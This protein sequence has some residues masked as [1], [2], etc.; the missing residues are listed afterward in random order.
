MNE[1]KTR[2]E[3]YQKIDT[4]R[5]FNDTHFN[6]GDEKLSVTSF[7]HG[8]IT[9]EK[10]IFD[11]DI[12]EFKNIDNPE[13]IL[14]FRECSFNCELSFSN[15]TLDRL[16]INDTK[17]I[18]SLDIRKGL[19]NN[20]SFELNTFQFSNVSNNNIPKLS[21][22]FYFSDIHFKN[23][24]S[25]E[26]INHAE[27]SIRFIDN[28]FG[29][30]KEDYNLIIFFGSTL[31]NAFFNR[32]KFNNL[33]NFNFVKFTQ[34]CDNKA[35][36]STKFYKNTFLKV[37][38]SNCKFFNFIEFNNCDFLSTTWFENCENLNN[39]H[40]KLVACEFKGFSLFNH[41]KI[42]FLNIDRCTF[43]KSSSFTDAEFNKIKLFEVKFGGGAYFDEMKINKVIDK[44]YLKDKTK[45]LEWK[46][47]LRAIKQELQK[48]E[49]KIDFNTYRNYELTAHYKELKLFG[50][51]TDTTILW[52]T[53]WSSN[54]GNWWWAFWFTILS[55][56]L[57]YSILY[58]VEHEGSF[59]LD[60]TAEFFIGYFRFFLVTDFFNPFKEDRSY[61]INVFS[62]LI[63]I[64]GKIF[65][66]FGI[67]EMIQS[68]RKFKA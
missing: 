46:R 27:G 38:F 6:L 42:N 14:E 50:N 21:T 61:L 48:T 62:W 22:N 52:A 45:I 36:K 37:D 58:R 29:K 19:S 47:T 2:A 17:T 33:V 30:K 60:K 10:C 54:F 44:S 56:F 8:W 63:F 64:I 16:T 7:S 4:I 12:L 65:I 68:F 24:F 9:F 53:K 20:H 59:N 13:L 35:L 66:A 28:V 55:A 51:F 31:N 5:I 57:W 39:T 49:N 25:F 18:K 11:C 34:I 32:N 67:Y 43:D 15:C 3:F 41:S 1:I 26:N 40:L 23:V